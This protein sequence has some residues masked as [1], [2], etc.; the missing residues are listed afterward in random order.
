MLG[1][2]ESHWNVSLIVGDKVI[3]QC[4]QTTSFK[5]R[6]AE[7]ELNRD[8]SAYQLNALPLGKA[9]SH[10]YFQW[11]KNAARGRNSPTGPLREEDV[12][13]VFWLLFHER[14]ARVVLPVPHGQLE[15]GLVRS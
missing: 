15:H 8:L 9:G 10:V 3:R 5:E 13:F 14:D 11:F 6:T 1:S 2:D 4:P 12:V 7:A